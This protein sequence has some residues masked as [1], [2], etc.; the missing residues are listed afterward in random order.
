MGRSMIGGWIYSKPVG[1]L[2]CVFADQSI[3]IMDGQWLACRLVRSLFG[4]SVSRS[5]HP[6]GLLSNQPLTDRPPTDRPP[7]HPSTGPWPNNQRHFFYKRTML[8]F[9]LS[10]FNVPPFPSGRLAAEGLLDPCLWTT[11][12]V[13]GVVHPASIGDISLPL[14]MDTTRI[15][16][17][18]NTP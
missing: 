7:K 2:V 4:L 15:D 6:A 12:Y 16:W 10:G 9:P 14:L 3:G 8:E 11:G 17:S 5:N 18:G 1:W 13:W